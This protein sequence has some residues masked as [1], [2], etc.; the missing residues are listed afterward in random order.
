M[1]RQ[2]VVRP[3]A[4]VSLVGRLAGVA[5]ILLTDLLLIVILRGAA[6]RVRVVSLLA[7]IA[8]RGWRRGLTSD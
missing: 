4:P 5:I 3:V 6:S 1:R 7:V 8:Y 2:V